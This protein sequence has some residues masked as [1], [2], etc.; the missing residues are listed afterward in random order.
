MDEC[1]HT[2]LS[3]PYSAIMEA[4]YTTCRENPSARLPQ[5]IGLSASLGVGSCDDDPKAH[6]I[7]ICANLDCECITYVRDAENVRELLEFN[8]PPK[9][10]QIVVVPPCSM[11]DEFAQEVMSLM[12]ELVTLSGVADPPH[13]FGTQQF[14]NWVVQ[15]RP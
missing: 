14:E 2:T 3:H 13:E 11:D 9:R 15:V 6:Y 4:Y 7:R 1:H 8:P 10:D 5:I 12:A